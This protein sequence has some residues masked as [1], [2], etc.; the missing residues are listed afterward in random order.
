MAEA[1]SNRY[2][3]NKLSYFWNLFQAL[4]TSW[5]SHWKFTNNYMTP[6][7]VMY[8]IDMVYWM[9]AAW[10]QGDYMYSTK[11]SIMEWPLHEKIEKYSK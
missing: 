2:M 9:D 8:L 10:E 1:Y 6:Y 11:S 3:A 4:K 7:Y 5:N